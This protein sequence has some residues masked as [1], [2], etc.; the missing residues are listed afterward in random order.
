[1]EKARLAWGLALVVLA[2]TS[3][4][5][6]AHA[7]AIDGNWCADDGRVMTIEGSSIAT[8]GGQQ[9]TGDYSRHAFAYVVPA[10][11]ADAGT[12]IAMVLLNEQTVAVKAGPAAPEEIWRRCD[13]I[14]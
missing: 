12:E 7:D 6:I 13:V 3:Y 2:S 1:M 14:S 4:S 8:P 10:G 11:E 9:T 5:G